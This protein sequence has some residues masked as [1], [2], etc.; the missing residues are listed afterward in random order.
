MG[1]IE[2][3]RIVEELMEIWPNEVCDKDIAEMIDCIELVDAI[4]KSKQAVQLH[5]EVQQFQQQ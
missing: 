3:V 5:W 1:A 2:T 4:E